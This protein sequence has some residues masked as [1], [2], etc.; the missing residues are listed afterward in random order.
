MDNIANDFTECDLKHFIQ[1]QRGEDEMNFCGCRE[2][3]KGG[4]FRKIRTI[5]D[6]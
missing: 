6:R 4:T 5:Q 1:I 3:I 2:E